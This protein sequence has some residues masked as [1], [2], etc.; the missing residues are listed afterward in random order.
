MSSHYGFFAIERCAKDLRMPDKTGEPMWQQKEADLAIA[1]TGEIYEVKPDSRGEIRQG[2]IQVQDY[3]RW[4]NGAIDLGR[5]EYMIGIFDRDPNRRW[6]PGKKFNEFSF[7]YKGHRVSV[8]YAEGGVAAYRT[9]E[10]GEECDESEL[11]K[12]ENPT[13][14]YRV[15]SIPEKFFFGVRVRL[16]VSAPVG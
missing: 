7:D 6:H 3:M 8:R 2:Q 15:F 14:W 16:P 11:Q 4:L 9:E 5:E 12:A 13:F 10:C 1:S